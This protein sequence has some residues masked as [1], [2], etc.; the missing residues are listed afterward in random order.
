MLKLTGGKDQ[1]CLMAKQC[2]ADEIF[3]SDELKKFNKIFL[4]SVAHHFENKTATF[5]ILYENMSSEA[6]C[7]V[8]NM[9]GCQMLWKDARE[10][11]DHGLDIAPAIKEA[12]FNTRTIIKLVAMK[13]TKGEWYSKL[14]G[15]IFAFI[16][17]KYSVEEIEEGIAEIDRTLLAGV[18]LDDEIDLKQ[19]MLCTIAWK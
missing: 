18:A 1:D 16:D 8:T 5:R 14:R 10:A 3:Q 15:R 19:E 17:E 4:C 12:G 9:H 2:T 13:C 11:I 6:V 7:L